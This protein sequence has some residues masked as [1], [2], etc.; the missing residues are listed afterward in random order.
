MIC[1]KNVIDVALLNLR[2]GMFRIF[3]QQ[4]LND[5]LLL[6]VIIGLKK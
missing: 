4:I 3:L 6:V 1:F 2:N 5:R